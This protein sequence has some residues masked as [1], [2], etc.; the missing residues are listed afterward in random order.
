MKGLKHEYWSRVRKGRTSASK[1]EQEN[2]ICGKQMDSVR[3][4]MLAA[5]T[6]KTV[7]RGIGSSRH[8]TN[9]RRRRT[10]EGPESVDGRIE[11]LPWN[12]HLQ[13][14]APTRGGKTGLFARVSGRPVVW[15]RQS[16]LVP[17]QAS[18]YR[19]Q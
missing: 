8:A 2:A 18:R 16:S 11:V 15:G 7:A 1:G 3:K 12:R 13:L 14:D 9:R 19:R 10:R 4:G 5:S 6:T 17:A